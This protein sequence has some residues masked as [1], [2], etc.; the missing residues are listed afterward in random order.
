ML[1]QPKLSNNKLPNREYE[2]KELGDIDQKTKRI[3][4]FKNN[5]MKKKRNKII[6]KRQRK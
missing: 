6:K 3:K 4:Q 1:Q 2:L 5:R